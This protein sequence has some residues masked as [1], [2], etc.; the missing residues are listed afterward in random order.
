MTSQKYAFGEPFLQGRCDLRLLRIG[1]H[2]RASSR[3]SVS[4]DWKTQTGSAMI[5]PVE[6]QDRYRQWTEAA[7][8]MFGADGRMDIL[9]VDVLDP[10]EVAL[11]W[12]QL[13]EWL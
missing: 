7:A 5:E 12:D 4:G 10:F 13:D 6:M 2:V 8:T 1:D 11:S 3:V 9:A